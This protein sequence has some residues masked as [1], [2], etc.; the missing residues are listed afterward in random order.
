MHTSN[1]TISMTEMT[2]KAFGIGMVVSREACDRV[3]RY[4]TSRVMTL[5]VHLSIWAE[6][7]W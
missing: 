7:G 6:L 5:L 4:Q 1:V 3:Q 2:G